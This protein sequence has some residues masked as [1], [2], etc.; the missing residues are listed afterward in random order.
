MPA[1]LVKFDY[2]TYVIN[3]FLVRFLREQEKIFFCTFEAN[4]KI[5]ILSFSFEVDQKN[6]A[7]W[8]ASKAYQPKII[9]HG[10]L[11]KITENI[12]IF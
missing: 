6:N 3:Y 2:E 9:F 10:T 7:L 4:R 5:N 12:F 8:F 11:S 1:I